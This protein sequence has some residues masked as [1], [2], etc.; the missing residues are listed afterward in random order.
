MTGLLI[1][2]VIVLALAL[3]AVVAR[4]RGYRARQASAGPASSARRICATVPATSVVSVLVIVCTV[5]GAPSPTGTRPTWT[6][7]DFRRMISWYGR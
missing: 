6:R 4:H 3:G 1:G 7:R 2:L 5:I